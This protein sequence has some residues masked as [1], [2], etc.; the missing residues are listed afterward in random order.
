LIVKIQAAPCFTSFRNELKVF[1]YKGWEGT[2][3]KEKRPEYETTFIS[4][5]FKEK[6]TGNPMCL[7][8]PEETMREVIDKID[9]HLV[10][11]SE[12]RRKAQEKQK[13]ET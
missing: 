3:R 6:S 1:A 8:F 5:V 4:F 2:H 7:G 9:K 10:S 11:V 12:T 13:N